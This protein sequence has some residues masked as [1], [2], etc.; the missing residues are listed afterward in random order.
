MKKIL[1]ALAIAATAQ[2]S[3][4]SQNYTFS[5]T[6]GTY[7]NLT[8]STAVSAAGWDEDQYLSPIGFNFSIGGQTVTDMAV[9]DNGMIL[10]VDVTAQAVKGAVFPFSADM[11]D[12]ANTTSP[13]VI[14]VATS[15]TAG[16]RI[17]KIEWKNAGFYDQ[18]N[19]T[20][21]TFVPF[22]N[23]FV[24]F[25][26][27]LYEGSNNVEVHFGSNNVTAANATAIF[28][29]TGGAATSIVTAITGTGQSS[30]LTG[31]A[32][33]GP[34]AT[35]ALVSFTNASTFPSVTGVPTSGTIYRFSTSTTGIA[36]NLNN[37]ALSVFPNPVADV[38]AIQGLTAKGNV[39]INVTDVLGKVV[40]SEKVAAAQN[41]SVNVSNLKKGAYTVEISSEEG[42]SIKQ[43]IK[44]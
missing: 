24:N 30:T 22:P 21:T 14:S 4:F 26:V 36:K 28:G 2:V 37:A 8:G 6:T 13:S 38:M 27:W 29:P 43:I 9:D 5:K 15:G 34:A 33:Q 23:D 41:V 44:Q 12:R 20:Q 7:A 10:F 25:Q 19:S 35:P 40:L 16:S 39:T 3:A 17:T 31:V 32:L 11:M 42:R 18:A 1:L